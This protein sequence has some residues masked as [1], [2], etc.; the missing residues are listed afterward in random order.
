MGAPRCYRGSRRRRVRPGLDNPCNGWHTDHRDIRWGCM[1]IHRPRWLVRVPTPSL[2]A[3]NPTALPGD[4][5]ARISPRLCNGRQRRRVHDRIPSRC[6]P[7]HNSGVRGPAGCSH[8]GGECRG[9]AR[10][11]CAA[12]HRRITRGRRRGVP[13]VGGRPRPVAGIQPPAVR[14]PGD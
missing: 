10:P 13:A 1:R 11:D 4:R 14:A 7:I 12:H 9:A 3:R 8:C 5:E 6:G 2:V